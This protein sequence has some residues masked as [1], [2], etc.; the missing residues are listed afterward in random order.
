[1]DAF[2]ASVE[3][4][5]D[6]VAQGQAGRRRRLADRRGVV[7]AA[8]YE[9][10]AFGVHSAMSMATAVRLCPSLV[11]VRPDFQ[12]YRAASQRRVRNLPRGD[13]A[14]RTAVARRGVSRRHRECLGRAAGDNGRE[15]AEGAHPRDDG[16]HGVGGRGAEQVSGED[17]V[18]MEEAGRPHRDQPRTGRTVPAAAARSTRCGAS[19]RSRP[20]SCGRRGIERLVDVRTADLQLLRETV[21]SLADW[22]RQ[23]AGGVDDRPVVPNRDA[24]S[25]GSENTYPEDLTDLERDSRARLPRWPAHAAGWLER[26]GAARADGDH[27]GPL[28]RFHDHHAQPYGARR[29]A[30]RRTSSRARSSCSTR[31]R[32]AAGQSGCW[33][34]A[35]TISQSGEELPL[36]ENLVI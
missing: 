1:M 34:S 32:P 10:R 33:A 14:R 26:Q 5:D 36:F 9:A 7:A 11:I 12:R 2:Y 15:A 4:R 18:G 16:A 19:G 20:A 13:A 29:R 30:R 21:G 31:P 17:R 23:L 3:Q 8:S 24:K 35:S 25:S 27:Q 28:L 6:P 22:L